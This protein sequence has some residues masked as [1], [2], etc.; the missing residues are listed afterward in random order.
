MCVVIPVNIGGSAGFVID[1]LQR[2]RRHVAQR[3]S[4]VLVFLSRTLRN[5]SSHSRQAEICDLQDETQ[6]DRVKQSQCPETSDRSIN[7]K[8]DRQFHT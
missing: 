5:A 7:Q 3:P 8:Q 1:I 2:F 6:K 4:L